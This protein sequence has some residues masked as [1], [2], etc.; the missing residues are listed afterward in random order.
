MDEGCRRVIHL[1]SHRH[2]NFKGKVTCLRC[3][4]E[5]EVEIKNGELMSSRKV[6]N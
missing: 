2:W 4:A 3:G 5:I 1:D 6:S